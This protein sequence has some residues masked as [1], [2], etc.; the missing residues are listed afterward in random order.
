MN[1]F[2]FLVLTIAGIIL[3][4]CSAAKKTTGNLNSKIKTEKLIDLHK[5]S[6]AN[7]TTLATRVQ[8]NYDDGS[9][10]QSMTISLR[11][12]KDKAIWVSAS[13]LGITMA[14]MYITPQHV[15]YYE[16]IG[17]TY[18]DGDFSLLSDWLA[19]DVDFN[20]VQNIL[21]GNSVFNVDE[22]QYTTSF[23]ESNYILTPKNNNGLLQHLFLINPDN[24]KMAS[25][26][27]MQPKEQRILKVDYLSYQPAGNYVFPKEIR[28]DALEINNQTKIALDFRQIDLN[29]RISFPFKIPNGYDEITVD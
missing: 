22:Y 9:S 27:I 20:M 16:T 12:E 4:S 15:S 25:Q 5:K 19:V 23:S 8:V 13:I 14:K 7:F 11:M 2:K 28:I 10:S 29:A 1:Y 18:F 3:V 24:F 6:E 26:Q 21:L 17:K